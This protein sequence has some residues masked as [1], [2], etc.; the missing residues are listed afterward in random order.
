MKEFEIATKITTPLMLAA[1]AQCVVFGLLK[2]ISAVKKP[3]AALRTIIRWAFILA[4][5]LGILANVSYL[6]IAG[7]AREVRFSG[8]VRDEKGKPITFAIVDLGGKKGRAVTDDYGEFELS[9]PGSRTAKE[10]QLSVSAPDFLSKTVPVTAA[11]AKEQLEV[12]LS[13][14]AFLADDFAKL[15]STA[16]I[17]HYLGN[18]QIVLTVNFSNP[19]SRRI[20]LENILLTLT[21]PPGKTIPI[22][23]EGMFISGAP[24]TWT[25]AVVPMVQLDKGQLMT[26]NCSFCNQDQGQMAA[27]IK[28]RGEVPFLND[29]PQP[30]STVYSKKLADEFRGLMKSR[31]IWVSGQWRGR[32]S[33]SVEGKPYEQTF[34]FALSNEEIDRMSAITKYYEAGFG[35]YP[36]LRFYP[37]ADAD[38]STVISLQKLPIQPK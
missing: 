37:V 21:S 13:H 25:A 23:M 38:P 22:V 32:L 30:E 26:L 36:D 12:K 20:T 9:V 10:Y 8:T 24:S 5:V 4:L 29:V 34:S 6:I 11:Q 15:E 27:L 3:N 16:S 1:L 33:W 17:R 31:M 28:A 2:G 7:F 35:V 18:P 19:E 14:P